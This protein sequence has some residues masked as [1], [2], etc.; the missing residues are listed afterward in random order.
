MEGW[1]GWSLKPKSRN[2]N[3]CLPVAML[4]NAN[5]V[6]IDLIIFRLKLIYDFLRNLLFISLLR[7]SILTL[8]MFKYVRLRLELFFSHSFFI[9]GWIWAIECWIWRLQ[10]IISPYWHRPATWEN[11]TN[12]SSW[13]KSHASWCASPLGDISI[14]SNRSCEM[15]IEASV[16]IMAWSRLNNMSSTFNLSQKKLVT[17][18]HFLVLCWSITHH[19]ISP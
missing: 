6:L 16:R 19:S 3:C 13:V 15:F 14:A 18:F 10:S 12:K 8:D 5:D 11:P 9:S 1:H 4:K 7:R 17:N 2:C